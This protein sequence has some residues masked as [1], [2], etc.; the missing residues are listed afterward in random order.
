[1]SFILEALRKSEAERRA[2][3]TTRGATAGVYVVAPPRRRSLG[4]MVMPAI[5][6]AAGI[7]VAV[8]WNAFTRDDAPVA[9]P[10]PVVQ[11]AG[12]RAVPVASAGSSDQGTSHKAAQVAPGAHAAPRKIADVPMPAAVAVV[13]PPVKTVVAASAAADVGRDARGSNT[14]AAPQTGPTAAGVKPAASVAAPLAAPL[15]AVVP[16]AL[17]SSG[18]AAPSTTA[19]AASAVSP[20]VSK[21]PAVEELP[22]LAV[23]GFANSE[24]TR[25][26]FAVIDNRIVREGEVFAPDLRLVQVADDGIVVEYKGQRYRP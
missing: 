18:V 24:D 8:G 12:D 23:S 9:V 16:P 25:S 1:M 5:A 2:A 13:R 20:A 11:A 21:A 7:G 17:A 10:P 3:P 19:V 14:V 26:R 4:T 15:P 22:K 6:L